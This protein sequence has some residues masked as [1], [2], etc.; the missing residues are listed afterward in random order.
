MKRTTI[1]IAL[2]S[3]I[4]FSYGFIQTPMCMVC[5]R[6]NETASNQWVEYLKTNY[7]AISD[8]AGL[9][10]ISSRYNDRGSNVSSFITYWH[11][12]VLYPGDS[13][14]TPWA[15]FNGNI[16]LSTKEEVIESLTASI[17]RD[18]TPFS[19]WIEYFTDEF[20]YV[21]ITSDDP[22]FDSMFHRIYLLVLEN[23]VTIRSSTI[24]YNWVLRD[25]FPFAMGDIFEPVAGDTI[26]YAIPY[27]TGRY[28]D[29]HRCRF[30]L[31]IDRPGSYDIMQFAF[32]PV[33]LLDYKFDVRELD[34]SSVLAEPDSVQTF[35]NEIINNGLLPDTIHITYEI[36][37]P[38][39]WE[40]EICIDSTTS[41]S[42]DTS[43]YLESEDR[44]TVFVRLTPDSTSGAFG[45]VVLIYTSTNTVDTFETSFYVTNGGHVLMFDQSSYYGGSPEYYTDVLDSLGEQYTYFRSSR[46]S[47]K[48]ATLRS[49]DIV[50]WYLG[51][52]SV[53]ISYGTADAFANFLD[54][55]G[56]L[57]I[58]SQSNTYNMSEAGPYPRYYRHLE[59]L[60][61]YLHCSSN[62]Y[63]VWNSSNSKDLYGVPGDPITNDLHLN[64]NDP[65]PYDSK[66]GDIITP[67][68]GGTPILYYDAERTKCAG[69]KYTGE[70]YTGNPFEVVVFG[71]DF[72]CIENFEDRKSLMINII[73][74]LDSASYIQ[75]IS[76]KTPD[77]LSLEVTPNPFNTS[78]E[79]SYTSEDDAYLAFHD[80]SGRLLEEVSVS[81]TGKYIWKADNLSSGIYFV[82]LIQKNRSLN[83]K[84]IL[85]K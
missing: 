58:S 81:G 71:L 64:L 54:N 19:T 26:T 37:V 27:K 74:W 79:I 13:M 8:S 50:I 42:S 25:I 80:L 72:A 16:P 52:S 15:G 66:D 23:E 11:G 12:T 40:V 21:K 73:A 4:G 68:A 38:P 67:I 44:E 46:G 56:K 83:K 24:P 76:N 61:S 51:T 69:L 6:P 35:R 45:S 33:P 18:K 3:F 77:K 20:V 82:R 78:C 41:F 22:T 49:F 48:A 53:R 34:S 47:I 30:A 1:I 63:S 75:E 85:L 55:G 31:F 29:L 32:G 43:I 2:L 59:F 39:E 14:R 84:I 9:I 10:I 5:V 28:W 70:G 36:D 7:P 60:E 57:F 62:R 65:A 17:G